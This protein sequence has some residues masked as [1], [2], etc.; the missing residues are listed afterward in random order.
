MP[1]GAS[2]GDDVFDQGSRHAKRSGMPMATAWRTTS[3]FV[4][5][6]GAGGGREISDE[7]YQGLR[8]KVLEELWARV[9]GRLRAVRPERA[10]GMSRRRSVP[11]S[12][13]KE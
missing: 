5:R 1:G 8:D 3:A 10:P 11:A 7:T 4:V 13:P 6:G 12:V 2:G 9:V